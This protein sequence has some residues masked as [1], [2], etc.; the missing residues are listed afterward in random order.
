LRKYG[1]VEDEGKNRWNEVEIPVS[2]L[3]AKCAESCGW[4]TA[5][6]KKRKDFIKKQNL[7]DPDNALLFFMP[8]ESFG[9]FDPTEVEDAVDGGLTRDIVALAKIFA[10]TPSDWAEAEKAILEAKKNKPKPKEDDEDDDNDEMESDDDEDHHDHHGHDHKEGE[11]CNHKHH[12]AAT[13]ADTAPTEPSAQ[14]A[15]EQKKSGGDLIVV[16]DKAKLR[17]IVLSVIQARIDKYGPNCSAVSTEQLSALPPPGSENS[18]D[19]TLRARGALLLKL[20][21]LKILE[22]LQREARLLCPE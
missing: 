7:V 11:V 14:P 6:V 13:S 2:L 20:G 10:A 5:E 12:E 1:Y 19:D 22:N 4:D 21:E 15:P 3:L 16:Q 8:Q 9:P 17:D 18:N